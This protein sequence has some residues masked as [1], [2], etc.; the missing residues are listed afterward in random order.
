MLPV[1]FWIQPS[2]PSSTAPT[3]RMGNE[4]TQ[5]R[6]TEPTWRNWL[7]NRHPSRQQ[8]AR[9][10]TQYKMQSWHSLDRVVCLNKSPKKIASRKQ[11]TAPPNN[12]TSLNICPSDK[13]LSRRFALWK[14]LTKEHKSICQV[15]GARRAPTESSS[16]S[17]RPSS[18]TQPNRTTDD[19]T[20]WPTSVQNI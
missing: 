14:A 16:P 15:L 3:R 8:S 6:S 10:P 2:V 4:Q 19:Q 9:V 17:C 13:P 1:I 5:T 18:R 11:A 12:P 20:G 7:G